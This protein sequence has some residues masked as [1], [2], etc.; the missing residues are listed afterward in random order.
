MFLILEI[1]SAGTEGLFLSVDEDRN[2]LFERSVRGKDIKKLLTQGLWPRILSYFGALSGRRLART[3]VAVG[4]PSVTT[5]I[6]IPLE[7]H[8]ERGN[9]KGKLALAELENLVAQ[10]MAKIFNGCRSEAARRLGVND[11][12]A[13]L[14]AAKTKHVRVDGKAVANPV[15]LTGKK[16]SLLL[17]L[18][19]ATRALFED[20]K[21]CF[22]APDHFFF[23]EAPQV[24]LSALAR[25]RTLPLGLV[26]AKRNGSAAAGSFYVLQ[27]AKE[28]YPVLYREPFAWSSSSLFRAIMKEFALGERAA[29]EVYHAYMSGDVS[30]AAARTLKRTLQPAV[31]DLLGEIEKLKVKGTLYIDMPYPVPLEFPHHHAGVTIEEHPVAELLAGLG[32]TAD[33]GFMGNGRGNGRRVCFLLYF[34]E[35]YF[36]KSDSEIN[37]KLRRRLHWLAE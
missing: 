5:T 23:G 8:R 13:V 25:V 9:G 32:F 37:R 24:H 33:P 20:L 35:A 21:E 34:L 19:F 3:V 11:L 22:N 36:D 12:D 31:H 1:S 29:K 17:E 16:I 10:A 28:D 15:G 30:D 27:K 26:A 2:I 7:L 6:P 14:V 18:T 4:D